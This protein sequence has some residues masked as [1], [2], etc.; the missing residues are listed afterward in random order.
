VKDKG[1]RGKGFSGGGKEKK[2][3]GGMLPLSKKEIQAWIRFS[4]KRGKKGIER[5][6]VRV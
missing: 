2:G 1:L 5:L 3:M 4:G 6:I